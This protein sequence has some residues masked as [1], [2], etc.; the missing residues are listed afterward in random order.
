[1]T[2][3]KFAKWSRIFLCSSIRSSCARAAFVTV[4][5]PVWKSRH[6]YLAEYSTHGLS[7]SIRESACAFSRELYKIFLSDTKERKSSRRF[8]AVML[9][10]ARPRALLRRRETA[11]SQADENRTAS[12]CLAPRRVGFPVNR[13][14]FPGIF[15]SPFIRTLWFL[16]SF[17]F[18]GTNI[19]HHSASYFL[20]LVLLPFTRVSRRSATGVISVAKSSSRRIFAAKS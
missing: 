9:P 12:H 13:L 16:R 5:H 2:A 10:F 11:V 7:R 1:M 4:R 14:G 20:S 15:S 18:L 17:M 19:A 8:L 3:A 6:I